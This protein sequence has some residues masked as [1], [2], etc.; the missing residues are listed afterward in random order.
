MARLNLPCFALAL[1]AA[2]VQ[3]L[4]AQPLLSLHGPMGAVLPGQVAVFT[5][6]GEAPND[7]T[8]AGFRQEAGFYC[9]AGQ[10]STVALLAVPL[11][12][13][14]GIFPLHLVWAGGTQQQWTNLRVDNSP[15]PTTSV[16]RV[17]KLKKKLKA[18]A[19]ANEKE[20]LEDAEAEALGGD[21]LWRGSFRWPLD[22]PMTITSP[23]G[24]T[25]IYNHGQAAWQ[26]RGID[27]RAPEGSVVSSPNQGVVLLARRHLHAT[28]GTVILG[29]GYGLSSS[30]FHLSKV[31][32]KRG[33][34]VQ[35]GDP[36]GLS[37]SSGLANGPHL[38][39]EMEL[40]GIP[41]QPQQWVPDQP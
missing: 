25:R 6:N 37:G 1:A 2:L 12:A 17:P 21:P 3:S 16:H 24:S 26:H 31:D 34:R 41:V 28:G 15:Y 9:L 10:Q 19:Q 4:V 30:Y 5:L 40:R 22:G 35:K 36:L 27:L 8:I 14:P 32:V 23:F 29:H 13:K 33:Q 38:H 18:A 11:N 7:L 39:W 20:V